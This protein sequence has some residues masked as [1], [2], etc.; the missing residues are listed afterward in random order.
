MWI[1]CDYWGPFLEESLQPFGDEGRAV[2]SLDHVRLTNELV[3]AP[4]P[5]WKSEEGMICPAMDRVVL[6][7]SEGVSGC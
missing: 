5:L 1:G 6:D 3:D 7:M 2:P 4:R